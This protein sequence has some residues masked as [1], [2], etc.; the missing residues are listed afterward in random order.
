MGIERTVQYLLVDE[1]PLNE[2]VL[3]LEVKVVGEQRRHGRRTDE[4]IGV[5]QVTPDVYRAVEHQLQWQADLTSGPVVK[6]HPARV[7]GQHDRLVPDRGG[8][9]VTG[10]LVDNGHDGAPVATLS[11][12]LETLDERQQRQLAHDVAPQ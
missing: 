3:G 4:N 10:P 2:V 5:D 12:G 1:Q 6:Q 8:V 7:G 11:E 9:R